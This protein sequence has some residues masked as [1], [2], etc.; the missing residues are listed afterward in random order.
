MRCY[1]LLLPSKCP[2]Q[3]PLSEDP[4]GL[5]LSKVDAIAQS[6]QLSLVYAK[7]S[8]LK[9]IALPGG[10]RTGQHSSSRLFFLEGNACDSPRQ[11]TKVCVGREDL[12]G[13]LVAWADGSHRKTRKQSIR[14]LPHLIVCLRSLPRALAALMCR[15]RWGRGDRS[16]SYLSGP[17]NPE[18]QINQQTRRLTETDRSRRRGVKASF[19]PAVRDVH[20]WQLPGD[21]KIPDSLT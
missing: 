17:W 18:S 21:T 13:N 6:P 16:D 8:P 15:Y 10:M 3:L 11:N 4:E 20:C 1:P 7:Q 5:L 12:M 14:S 2:A 9:G 19:N